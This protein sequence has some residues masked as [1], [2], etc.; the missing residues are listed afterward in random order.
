MC[1]MRSGGTRRCNIDDSARTHAG[2]FAGVRPRLRTLGS[3]GS[4]VAKTGANRCRNRRTGCPAVRQGRKRRHNAPVIGPKPL[5]QPMILTACTANARRSCGRTAINYQTPWLPHGS[6]NSQMPRF[7]AL[8]GSGGFLFP[9]QPLNA[10]VLMKGLCAS[11]AGHHLRKYSATSPATLG[12]QTAFGQT[13]PKAAPGSWLI[14][15]QMSE[16]WLVVL[17]RAGGMCS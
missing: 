12:A 15:C 3:P 13:N 4:T 1:R 14:L 11:P 8:V 16:Q 7:R 9:K 5:E 2:G 17:R 6:L 10:N